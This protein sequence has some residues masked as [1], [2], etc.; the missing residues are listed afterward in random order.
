MVYEINNGYRDLK[1]G[2]ILLSNDLTCKVCDF[3]MSKLYQQEVHRTNTCRVG[4]L[5]YM[6][7]KIRTRMIILNSDI[8]SHI[9]MQC[10]RHLRYC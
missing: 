6:V 9:F 1:P 10:I 5:F 2:N 4:T 8:K 7:S 3:G